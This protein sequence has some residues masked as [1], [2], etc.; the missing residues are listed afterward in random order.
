MIKLAK[1]KKQPPVCGSFSKGIEGSLSINFGVSG[2]SRCDVGCPHHP[3]STADNPTWS[4]Y[5]ERLERRHDR[6]QLFRKLKRHE[7]MPASQVIAQAIGEIAHRLFQK[8]ET[9][10]WVRL[11]TNG[12]LPNPRQAARDKPLRGRLKALLT[13]CR[14]NSV[15]VHIPVET[16]RKAAWYRALIGDLAVIRESAVSVKRFLKARGAVS[17]VVGEKVQTRKQRVQAARLVAEQRREATGRK[18]VVCPA[19]LNSWASNP[20]N[21][22]PIP[23]NPR[24]KCGACTACAQP[25][26]D[27]IYPLH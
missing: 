18:V 19:I 27:I 16:E 9:I 13:M 24:A 26:V 15:P 22:K 2:G 7:A 6:V 25:L 20:C 17:I 5:A 4:C 12:S 3:E 23:A 1:P 10:P 21:E 11:S 8:R 14:Q